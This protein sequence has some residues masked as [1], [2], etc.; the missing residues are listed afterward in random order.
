M[1]RE[2]ST[3]DRNDEIF[4]SLKSD[5][6]KS[7]AYLEVEVDD[8]WVLIDDLI[9]DSGI[10]FT[11]ESKRDKIASFSL[12][13]LASSI[14]FN[15]EN[16]NGKYSY[17]SGTSYENWFDLD[18]RIKL[19]AGYITDIDE[20]TQTM[21][22]VLNGS[23]A[24]TFYSVYNSG[25]YIE[26][27]ESNEDGNEDIYFTDV[28]LPYYDSVLYDSTTYSKSSYFVYT[29]DFIN[30]D[31]AILQEISV[32]ANN[33]NGSIYYRAFNDLLGANSGSA[34]EDHW[35]YGGATINGEQTIEIDLSGQRYLQVAIVYDG[36]A[37]A[38][39]LRITD[40]TIQ[41]NNVFEDLYQSVYYL[42]SPS[43]PEP[44]A[45]EVPEVV[46]SGRDIFKRAIE[47][48]YLISDL[49]A[50]TNIDDLIKDICDGIG[51][52]YS[53][54]SIAD[55]SSYS[56][57]TIEIGTGEPLKA[58]DIFSKIMFILN[59]D[60][61]PTG[62]KYYMYTEY[63]ETI[64]DKILYVQPIPDTFEADYVFNYQH[65]QEIGD[66]SKNYGRALK[67]ITFLSEKLPVNAESLLD[68]K[69]AQSGTGSQAFSW[70]GN[71]A[72]KRPVW[73]TSDDGF[74]LDSITVTPTTATAI[75]S[76]T[77]GVGTWDLDIRG[78]LWRGKIESPSFNGTGINDI[79]TAGTYVG[80]TNRTYVVKIDS[81]GATDTFKWS[82]DGGSTYPHTAISMTGSLQ[83]LEYGIRINFKAITGHT[84]NDEW[85]INVLINTPRYEG[86]AISA[87]NFISG[88]G[89]TSEDINEFIISSTE[90]KEVA[91]GLLND[92]GDP[93]YE[94]K[95]LVYPFLN[96]IPK[97]N[98]LSLIWARFIFVDTLHTTTTIKY[99]WSTTDEST[100]FSLDDSGSSFSDY[101]TDGFIYDSVLDYDNGY[102][103]D[104]MYSNLLSDEEVETQTEENFEYNVEVT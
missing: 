31:F 8:E 40:I 72:Y 86:E 100:D 19:H 82:N 76:A 97:I 13:P 4:I 26:L 88:K 47:T 17:G 5:N 2:A 43:F 87:E 67:R 33:S 32:T 89:L 34:T 94:T 102:L 16:L 68:S 55:L 92:Y 60:N 69:S 62:Y 101:A 91:E 25:G 46:C 61:S 27:S 90:A 79:T 21:S 42:D 24:Y 45:P 15:V 59:K 80:G 20:D 99:F 50:G 83:D 65:Y 41:Y 57:R 14:G 12:V 71:A 78:C 3:E 96:L 28:F 66:R 35:I 49:S 37:W 58:I 48:D 74:S 73:S 64:D 84:L 6:H 38:D 53:A 9:E 81:V 18:T 63:D 95:N 10:V 51:V 56:A 75:V 7:Y 52:S 39:D 29:F 23:N 1:P 93:I 30:K 77:T 44:S 11:D 104:M 85:T 54:T 36:I 70:S 103:Y 22:A 98:E